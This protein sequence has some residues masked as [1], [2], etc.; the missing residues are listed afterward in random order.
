MRKAGTHCQGV[1]SAADAAASVFAEADT[2]DAVESRLADA[3]EWW[4]RH[5]RWE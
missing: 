5:T 3:M 4:N 1:E 2:T